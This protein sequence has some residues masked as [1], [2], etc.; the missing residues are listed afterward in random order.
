VQVLLLF[1]CTLRAQGEAPRAL[2]YVQY[3]TEAGCGNT[4]S[5]RLT[6]VTREEERRLESGTWVMVPKTEVVEVTSFIKLEHIVPLWAEAGP[7]QRQIFY[8]IKYASFC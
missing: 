5:S 1:W 6:K 2:A 3:F 7:G 8:I 4:D